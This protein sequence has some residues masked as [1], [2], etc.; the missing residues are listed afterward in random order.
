MENLI[1][2]AKILTKRKIT[3]IEILDENALKN[4]DSLFARF[5]EAL[6]TDRIS[7]DEAAAEALYGDKTERNNPRYRKLKSRFQRRLYNT[8]FFI[9]VNTA[10]ASNKEQA[11]FHCH[12]EWALIE[13]MLAHDARQAALKQARRTLSTALKFHLTDIIVECARLLR[14]DAALRE[15]SKSFNEY[16]AYAEEYAPKLAAEI[17]A[18]EYYQQAFLFYS[19]THF[20]PRDAEQ[21]NTL[22]DK[23][24]VLS[25]EYPCPNVQY[26]KYRVW[27][28]NLE[29]AY[30]YEELL[31]VCKQA[32]E[33]MQQHR[34]LFTAQEMSF[35]FNKQMLAYLHQRQAQAGNQLAN[36]VLADFYEAG[37]DAWYNFK[38]YHTL[39]LLHAGN[40]LRAL[41]IF[42]QLS[43]TPGFGKLEGTRRDKWELIEIFLSYLV[44]AGKLSAEHLNKQL[45]RSFK[46]KEEQLLNGNQEQ[47]KSSATIT[48]HRTVF[49]MLFLLLRRGQ[50]P[51]SAKVD[52]LRKLKDY[53]LKKTDYQRA[54][55]FAQ[56][57]HE[58]EKADFVP[59]DTRNHEAQWQQLRGTPFRYR[60]KVTEL[61]VIPYEKLWL[62]LRE[63][64]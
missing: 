63:Q 22:M 6:I 11:H 20:K 15:D 8:L 38:E 3:R 21:L 7:D 56:M 10:A 1:E 19:K 39:L 18:E 28:L 32:I 37:S 4:N 25:G 34:D 5:Y 2:V 12:K 14:K 35:F 59:T 50:A 47:Q 57:L 55:I 45:R 53:E 16:H 31:K 54:R 27:A 13:I 26:F 62:L 41:S 17:K 61:E 64:L 60:G 51:L 36:Q 9:D 40:Y 23:I 44:E 29:V 49:Q 24:I 52:E 42:L 30:E 48:L 46:E 43:G 33:Y 58:L